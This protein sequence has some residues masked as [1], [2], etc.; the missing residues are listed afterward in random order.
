MI[1]LLLWSV[2]RMEMIIIFAA[3]LLMFGISVFSKYKN[4]LRKL[5]SELL[6]ELKKQ[7]EE[8]INKENQ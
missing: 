5:I 2:G 6:K 7:P 1:E 4:D 3:I 8:K